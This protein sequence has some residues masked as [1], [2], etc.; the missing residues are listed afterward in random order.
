MADAPQV[1]P[2][3]VL[4]AVLPLTA[5]KD[6][7]NI[8]RNGD[9]PAAGRPTEYPTVFGLRRRN[10]WILFVLI[11]TL[12]AGTS[13]GSMGGALAVERAKYVACSREG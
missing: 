10:F 7:S 13:G 9:I 12:M 11:V 8:E 1:V 2:E 4:E 6:G 3:S 5:E